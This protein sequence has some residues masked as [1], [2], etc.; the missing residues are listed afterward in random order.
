[1]RARIFTGVMLVMLVALPACLFG[2][3]DREGCHVCG[4]WV[5]MYMKT[6]HLA[7]HKDGSRVSFCSISCASKYLEE[8]GGRVV[9]VM[10][11]DYLSRD[12]VDARAAFYLSGS[13]VFGV[14]T[15]TSRLAFSS[16]ARAEEFQKK[17]GGNIIDF[18]RALDELS[19]E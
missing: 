19:K 18:D 15:Y 7:E 1:M 3:E 13:D 11:A 2:G 17:H 9:K 10:A 4:M 8:H 16:R 5:D 6:R 12:L 14:M